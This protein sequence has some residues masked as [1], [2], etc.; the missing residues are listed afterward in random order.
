MRN[1]VIHQQIRT[2]QSP[3]VSTLNTFLRL[4]TRSNWP[5]K[6]SKSLNTST[7]QRFEDQLVKPATSANFYRSEEAKQEKRRDVSM[8][9]PRNNQ[10]E[11]AFD[12]KNV[13]TQCSWGTSRRRGR[14]NHR[15]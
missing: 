8:F 14:L 10:F 4:A 6:D 3:I 15:S 9:Y 5:Y 12:G 7:G 13:P 11:R 2:H 1:I